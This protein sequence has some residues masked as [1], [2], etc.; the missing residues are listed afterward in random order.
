MMIEYTT[1]YKD[2]LLKEINATPEEYLP[3]LL[4]IV[5]SYRQSVSLNPADESFRQGW[6]EAMKGETL[7]LAGLWEGIDAE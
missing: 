1:A 4:N 7:P 3:A 2:R 5:R 6:Q